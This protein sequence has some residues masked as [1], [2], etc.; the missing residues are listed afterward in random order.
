MRCARP[1]L[2]L[3]ALGV[4]GA[5]CVCLNQAIRKPQREAVRCDA[6]L[7]AGDHHCRIEVDGVERTF[8]V[9][10]PRTRRRPA[11]LVLAFHGTGSTSAQ[12]GHITEFSRKADEEGFVVVYP[13]GAGLVPRW[14]VAFVDREFS[15]AD[16][17]AF[18]R[19]L[20]AWS[21]SRLEVDPRRVYATGMS[22]GGF[23]SH[24]LACEMPETFAAIAPVAAVNLTE[25]DPERP[26]PVLSFHGRSDPVVLY[27]G[28]DEV[29]VPSV[30]E[31]MRRWAE[32]NECRMETVELDRTEEVVCEAWPG[33]AGNA[34][35][36]LC[37][38]G[39]GGHT[40]PGGNVPRHV[41]YTTQQADATKLMWDF[42]ERHPM[43]P[44]PAR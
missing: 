19:R 24:V 10:V 33:C 37:T 7:P 38:A 22:I 23:F 4:F 35:V 15:T 36:I 11:P 18:V 40:W 20:L 30:R 32:R 42:F 44:T 9:H 6:P 27:G 21:R 3:A 28:A 8:R 17:L 39:P 1:T 2:L 43:P 34:E 16:D 41:G 25:C 5:G 12:M 29:G 14:N 26:V 31:G 13:Q